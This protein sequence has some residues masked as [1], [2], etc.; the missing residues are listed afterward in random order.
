MAERA[1]AKKKA[2]AKKKPPK[3]A[4]GS[5]GKVAKVAVKPGIGHN[6]GAPSPALIKGHHDKIDEI[7]AKLK[8]AKAKYDQVKGE[9]RSYYATVKQ[10]GIVVDD[11][12]LARELD[13]RDHGSVVVG[14][15]NVGEYL[16]AIKSDLAKVQ[17]LFAN[18]EVLDAQNA[19]FA[20]AAAFNNQEPRDNNPHKPGSDAHANWDAAWMTAANSAELKDGEGATIN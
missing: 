16:S 18:I 20:G 12:K 11:F 3:G 6:S 5:R 19:T 14:Y 9:L 4:Q 15:A 1:R 8:T 13:K 10:D 2:A 17:G 7:E